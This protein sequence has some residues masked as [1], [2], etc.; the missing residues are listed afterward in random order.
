MFDEIERA[1]CRP[2]VYVAG[3]DGQALRRR[4]RYSREECESPSGRDPAVRGRDNEGTISRQC[5][6]FGDASSRR[7]TKIEL[8][9]VRHPSSIATAFLP[10]SNP[11]FFRSRFNNS[12][13]GND[14][15]H[16]RPSRRAGT[17]S[18]PARRRTWRQIQ[19]AW[20]SNSGEHEQAPGTV[21][22]VRG[23]RTLCGQNLK[24]RR[25]GKDLR[26][27]N[28]VSSF[29]SGAT[30]SKKRFRRCDRLPTMDVCSRRPLTRRNF[31][32]PGAVFAPEIS[33]RRV[34]SDAQQAASIRPDNS[35]RGGSRCFVPTGAIRSARSATSGESSR[36]LARYGVDARSRLRSQICARDNVRDERELK[37]FIATTSTVA[38]DVVEAQRS[39]R[40]TREL[41]A[42]ADNWNKIRFQPCAS[43]AGLVVG[44]DGASTSLG[45]PAPTTEETSTFPP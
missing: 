25:N 14:R 13:C 32:S 10:E 5:Q 15:C 4:I 17:K 30:C 3:G 20:F 8:V 29:R 41:T 43:T 40:F 31:S 16:D 34:A 7:E 38:D 23:A 24:I 19:P 42:A 21:C 27:N 26:T 35:R 28:V 37:R 12:R 2:S 18:D 6:R 39:L 36:T 22:F 11:V 33:T 45:N 44:A 9:Q 1:G